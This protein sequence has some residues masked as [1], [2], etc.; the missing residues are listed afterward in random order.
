MG[1][2]LA[3]DWLRALDAE[4]EITVR[5]ARTGE[6]GVVIWAVVAGGAAFLR[7][8][9]G[10]AGA[11]YRSALAE[12]RAEI[13]AAAGRVAVVVTPVTDAATQAMVSAA[14]RAKYGDSPYLG[15]ML[16]EAACATT[17][18]LSAA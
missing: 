16:G 1:K 6:A 2:L 5:T 9:R 4:R 17:L 10:R 12:G 15:A 14:Y 18:L 3:D 13:E 8:Y 7:S 11:W